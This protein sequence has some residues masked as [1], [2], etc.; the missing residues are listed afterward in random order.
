MLGGHRGRH[1]GRSGLT[2]STGLPVGLLPKHYTPQGQ[3]HSASTK[4]VARWS[5]KDSESGYRDGLF[6][7]EWEVVVPE[8]VFATGKPID[9][10]R[11]DEGIRRRT[12]GKFARG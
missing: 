10:E 1:C 6:Y 9:S 12:V 5:G 8:I 2:F 7:N 3:F 4:A 11:I